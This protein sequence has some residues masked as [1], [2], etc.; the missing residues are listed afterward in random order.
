M[1][2]YGPTTIAQDENAIKLYYRLHIHLD[3]VILELVS[4]TSN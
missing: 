2:W 3:D 1:G 4:E